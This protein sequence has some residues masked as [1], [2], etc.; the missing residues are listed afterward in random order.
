MSNGAAVGSTVDAQIAFASSN[1]NPFRM[2]IFSKQS[3]DEIVDATNVTTER[4]RIGTI[5]A[6]VLRQCPSQLFS[7]R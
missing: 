6:L 5:K 7:I 2:H 4:P 3:I 1:I